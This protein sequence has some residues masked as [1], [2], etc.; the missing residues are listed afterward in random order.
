MDRNV[1]EKIVRA[2]LLDHATPLERKGQDS[3]IRLLYKDVPQTD[4]ICRGSDGLVRHP[5][6]V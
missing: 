5:V 3:S 6:E 1:A 2:E 4:L